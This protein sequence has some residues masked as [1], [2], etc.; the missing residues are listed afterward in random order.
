VPAAIAS[1]RIVKVRI[2]EL[3]RVLAETI[4]IAI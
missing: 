3:A 4:T 2:L 1:A